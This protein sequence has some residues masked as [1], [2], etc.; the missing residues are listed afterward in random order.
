MFDAE[1]A[2]KLLN[3]IATSSPWHT[4]QRH[5]ELLRE[6]NFQ[7]VRQFGHCDIGTGLE[8]SEFDFE[9]LAFADGSRAV[10]I[11]AQNRTTPWTSWVT[12]GAIASWVPPPID[13]DLDHGTLRIGASGTN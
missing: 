5:L 11:H 9:S 4:C 2:V 12:T 1:I 13:T 8:T 10:R 7:F 3:R 6:G